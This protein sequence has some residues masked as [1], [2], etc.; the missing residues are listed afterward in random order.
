VSDE[1]F[2]VVIVGGGPA[3]L[4]AAL[5]LGRCRRR[6]LV[7][8]SGKPR[9]RRARAAHGFFTRDGAGPHDLLRI[10]REQ[11]A[12]Y[13]VVL[14]DEEVT[15]VARAD[16]GE[17][18]VVQTRGAGTFRGKK[19]LLATGMRDRLPDVPGIDPLFGASVHVCPYCDGWE[20][21]DLP[22]AVYACDPGAAEFTLALLTWSKDIVLFTDGQRLSNE[23]AARL[24][25]NGVVVR[26]EEVEAFEGEGDQ[27]VAVRLATGERVGRR[28]LFVHLG[29][30]QAAPFARDLG[31]P[32]IENGCIRTREGERAGPEGLYVA[33]D[34]SHDLQLVAIA[35]AEGVKAAVAINGELRR[36]AYR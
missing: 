24:A 28:S 5:V 3:G 6:V 11:L 18:W 17:G 30:D 1:A 16:A 8:D 10:G 19:V 25:R 31:C 33:G 32:T 12:P 27:L 15:A 23:D 34:A 13:D 36:D 21:R 26:G 29:Q 14:A 20:A 4:S 22:F 7:I 2:D 9:N 35:V